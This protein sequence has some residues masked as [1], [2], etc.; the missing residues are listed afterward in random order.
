GG[1]VG[2]INLNEIIR[3]AFQNASLGYYA[4][5]P[6]AGQGLMREGLQLVL[7][8]AFTKLKLHRLEADIQPGNRSSIAL[9][10]KCGFI[11]EGTARRLLKVRDRWQ[12]HQR[13]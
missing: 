9:V 10:Q 4:F 3:G 13:W 8:D 12:D 11:Y 5:V 6:H 7:R 2:V 1:L